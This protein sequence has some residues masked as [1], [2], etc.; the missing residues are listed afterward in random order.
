MHANAHFQRHKCDR[1]AKLWNMLSLLLCPHLILEVSKSRLLVFN[2]K[3]ILKSG[4]KGKFAD[5]FNK[6]IICQSNLQFPTLGVLGANTA[7]AIV[8]PSALSIS[9]NAAGCLTDTRKTCKAKHPGIS[10]PSF[11]RSPMLNQLFI[12]M[13]PALEKEESES[14]ELRSLTA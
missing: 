1:R 9:I 14:T 2:D 12:T 11:S 8:A 6:G 3:R 7:A 5:P 13:Q 10:F 4:A